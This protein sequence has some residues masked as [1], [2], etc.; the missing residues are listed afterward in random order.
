MSTSEE[1]SDNE[2]WME[3]TQSYMEL[4]GSRKSYRTPGCSDHEA[5]QVG[6]DK[7]Y[8]TQEDSSIWGSKDDEEYWTLDSNH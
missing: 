1:W 8:L 3:Q 5:P 7:E 6:Q 4:R 2:G